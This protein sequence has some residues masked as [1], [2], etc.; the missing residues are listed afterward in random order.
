MGLRRVFFLVSWLLI[1]SFQIISCGGGGTTGGS[2]SSSTSFPDDLAVASPTDA[3][4]TTDSISNLLNASESLGGEGP[5][6]ATAYETEKDNIN[7]ILNATSLAACGPNLAALLSKPENADCYGPSI[8]FMNHPDGDPPNVEDNF[9]GGDNGMWST[10]E[11]GSSEACAATQLN[12]RIESVKQ[13]VSGALMILAS[14]I[15]TVNNTAGLSLPTD[16]SSITITNELN[17]M[18]SAAGVSSS[19]TVTNGTISAASNS[20]GT[21]D[22]TYAL[23][24][25]LTL[26]EVKNPTN[27]IQSS[28]TVNMTHRPLVAD[29]STYRGKMNYRVNN[30]DSQG[31]CA[32]DMG[33]LNTSDITEAGSV[34]Y[35]LAS[36]TDLRIDARYANLCGDDNE[37]GFDTNGILDPADKGTIDNGQTVQN[38]ADFDGWIGNFSRL[39]ANANPVT[40]AGNY[41]FMWQAGTGDGTARTFVVNMG[42]DDSDGVADASAFFGYTDSSI[43]NEDGDIVG[44]YCNWAGPNGGVGNNQSRRQTLAQQQDMEFNATSGLF[45]PTASNISYAPVVDCSLTTADLT[46]NGGNP[47]SYDID[48]DGDRDTAVELTNNLVNPDTAISASGYTTPTAPTSL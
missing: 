41:A 25:T 29:N 18:I 23:S 20:V 16:G 33:T 36:A 40:G 7:D 45:E 9:P 39:T 5:F 22:Y 32:R 11:P 34:T 42:D 19:A 30:D 1:Y 17:A 2:S 47:F 44:I 27:T 28:M 15:C 4:T 26:P 48:A 14:M 3:N 6:F 10:T 13:K 24:V 37:T 46:A 31:N 35:E 38:E 8:L 43:E 12:T 21:T